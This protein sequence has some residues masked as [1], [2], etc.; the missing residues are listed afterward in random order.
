MK[1]IYISSYVEN[2]KSFLK[3]YK[4]SKIFKNI[5]RFMSRNTSYIILYNLVFNKRLDPFD[6]TFFILSV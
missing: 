4:Y 2:E 6:R 3:S 5:Q 1:K